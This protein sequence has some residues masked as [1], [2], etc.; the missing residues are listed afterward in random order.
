MAKGTKDRMIAAAVR[1][2]A[3]RGLQGASLADILEL[4][5]APRG[6]VYHHFPGGKDEL[7]TAAVELAGRR[8]LEQLDGF[9]GRPPADVAERFFASWRELLVRTQYRSGCSVLAVTVA[10]DSPELLDRSAH[11]FDVWQR[12]LADLFEHGGLSREAAK[13]YATTLIAVSEGA[14]VMCRAQRSTAP[15]DSVAQQFVTQ[16]RSAG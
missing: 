9:D 7:I 10:A 13:T 4:A 3:T 16:L 6:S 12:R 2:L 1:L 11:T 15:L 5:N 14:V 8:S